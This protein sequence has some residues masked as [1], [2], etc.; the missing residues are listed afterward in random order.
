[1][2]NRPRITFA[3]SLSVAIRGICE[4]VAEQRNLKIHLGVTALVLIVG[5]AL[6]V[7]VLQWAMIVM[8]IG[9]VIGTELLN[10]AIETVVDR[11][12]PD[13][14]DLSRK[15]KDISAGAVLTVT[16]MAVIV[17]LLIFGERIWSGTTDVPESPLPR[18]EHDDSPAGDFSVGV[19]DSFAA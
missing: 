18:V 8:C 16:V 5:A 15:A 13:D 1:M 10:T 3:R 9:I 6:Q 2:Q 14:H 19:R 11:I 7:S 4:A 12:S 17:G